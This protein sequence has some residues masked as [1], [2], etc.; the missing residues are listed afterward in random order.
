MANNDVQ[1]TVGANT[2][3]FQVSIDNAYKK[4][5]TFGLRNKDLAKEIDAAF[6]SMRNVADDMAGSVETAFNSMQIKSDLASAVMRE[7]AAKTSAS[8]LSDF[9]K[10][11]NSAE[12]T[13]NDVMRS[14]RKLG[15]LNA[16]SAASVLKSEFQTLGIQSA[17]SIEL[18]KIKIVNA[19]K[20]IEMTGTKAPQDILRAHEAMTS[21]IERLDKMLMTSAERAAAARTAAFKE[22]AAAERASYAAQGMSGSGAA[23][24]LIGQP[25]AGAGF[26]N[27]LKAQ[28]EASAASAQTR[29]REMA[30][31]AASAMQGEAAAARLAG[32]VH[33]GSDF[34]AQLKSQMEGVKESTQNVH[35][36]ISGWS[37]A[38][39]VAI[40]K[41]Q[42]LYSL[43]NSIMSAIASV[44]RTAI[45]A[46]EDYK[47]SIITN[48]ALITSMQGGTKDVGKAYQEN[49]VYAEA[50]EKVLIKMDS[51]TAGS[52]KNLQDMNRTFVEQGVILDINNKKAVAGYQ[53]IAAAIAVIA[54]TSQN[55]DIQWIQEVKGLMS[56]TMKPG[57]E[58]LGMLVGIDKDIVAKIKRWKEA[59]TIPE[60][61]GPMLIGFAA[62]KGDIEAL[63]KTVSTTMSTIK[64]E[65]LRG[66]LSEGFTEIIEQLKEVNK[67]ARDNKEV[68][69]AMLKEGFAEAKT[70]AK[71]MF[72]LTSAIAPFGKEIWW[73]AVALGFASITKAIVGMNLALLATPVGQISA[74][75]GL[76][77]AVA[78]ER[79][80][81]I[82]NLKVDQSEVDTIRD[83]IGKDMRSGNRPKWQV[84]AMKS[85]FDIQALH[86]IQADK[87]GAMATPAEIASYV[88][89]RAIV[90]YPHEG[91]ER[92]TAQGIIR[93]TKT[94]FDR[95]LI[96]QMTA[97]TPVVIPVVKRKGNEKGFRENETSLD[98]AEF[99]YWKAE[100]E[101]IAEV[102]I[103]ANKRLSEINE[104]G[105]SEGT[106]SLDKYLKTR[107]R[108]IE[109]NIQFEIDDKKQNLIDAQSKYDKSLTNKIEVTN[110]KGEVKRN[111]QAETEAR[112]KAAALVESSIKSVALAQDKLTEARMKGAKFDDKA[113]EDARKSA[114]S[115]IGMVGDLETKAEKTPLERA[116]DA[117]TKKVEDLK[118]KFSEMKPDVRAIFTAESG[119]TGNADI[120]F[121]G[122]DA[123]DRIKA[124]DIAKNQKAANSMNMSMAGSIKS[125]GS[126]SF[127]NKHT[128]ELNA[129]QQLADDKLKIREEE[130]F[131]MA[132]LDEDEFKSAEKKWKLMETAQIEHDKAIAKSKELT[133]QV[134]LGSL[135]D[136]LGKTGAMLMKGNREQFEEGKKMAIASAGVSMALGAVEAFTSM[137]KFGIPG[138]ILGGIAAAAVVGVGMQGIAQINAQQ[139][140]GREF[141]GPVVAGQS[142]V[143]G[144][145]RPEL[146]T[147]GASG[148]ITPYVPQQG[149]S[150]TPSITQVNNF[151]ADMSDAVRAEIGRSLP[152]IRAHAL[153][154]V[155]Q[156]KSAGR[157]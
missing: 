68:M 3:Q 142:Y 88:A 33:A 119:I 113:Y 71:I 73:G 139:Y 154:A 77:T 27:D 17:E 53:S 72:E 60:N 43:I 116:L 45:D 153:A 101:R 129:A 65:I 137:A 94:T 38:S 83:L 69:Q 134:G 125:S 75:V 62:A 78:T 20:E 110:D 39:V 95:D 97:P 29:S 63:Y 123:K 49:K 107:E 42:V 24:Q 130:I 28:M 70:V 64:N 6:K 146:F 149:R 132:K 98:N 25:L 21:E 1:I 106:V 61:I 8:W 122:D 96:A 79:V 145:K 100:S 56:G 138:M 136:S 127:F 7:N 102:Q 2:E 31:Y 121:L 112:I 58:L 57:N 35:E 59:G 26:G 90:N 82:K 81:A 87:V 22:S 51:E 104:Q 117:I 19:F 118:V 109:A 13:A 76:I 111:I 46:I 151:S 155:M 9:G 40:A 128:E 52:Y 50:L 105:Y 47:S 150:D 30:S 44:P 18:A 5:N 141:G 23:A 147:P 86:N 66:G 114:N 135:A 12:T 10:I 34:T 120:N 99:A 89:A 148:V 115:A 37:L 14:W 108:L 36:G 133:L 54:S 131:N 126:T 92:N 55:G 144:E 11:A 84:D 91:A 93:D 152:L 15:E 4:I 124:D 85:N 156:A 140:E 74:L 48:S 157:M 143:V 41:I 67:W 103:S 16:T 32:N 80:L